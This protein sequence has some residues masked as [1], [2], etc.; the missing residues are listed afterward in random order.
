MAFLSFRGNHSEKS[1]VTVIRHLGKSKNYCREAPG[2]K[3]HEDL[4]SIIINCSGKGNYKE[5]LR[6]EC[7]AVMDEEGILTIESFI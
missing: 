7:Y 1:G 2:K 6:R 3:T 4:K 5:I